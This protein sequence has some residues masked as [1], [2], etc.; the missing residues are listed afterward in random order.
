[1]Q[2]LREIGKNSLPGKVQRKNEKDHAG[3][4][5]DNSFKETLKKTS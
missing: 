5:N 2:H 4:V 1:V 3:S